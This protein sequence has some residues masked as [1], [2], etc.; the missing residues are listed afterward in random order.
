M[1]GQRKRKKKT[2]Y[3]EEKIKSQNKESNR[4]EKKNMNEIFI[5][6]H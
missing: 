2:K 5:N 6:V 3:A 4:V 1:E